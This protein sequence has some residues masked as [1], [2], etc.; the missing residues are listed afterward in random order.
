MPNPI[1]D[2]LVENVIVDDI[3]SVVKLESTPEG[4]ATVTITRPHRR[5]ALDALTI[6]GLTEAF[7]TLHGADHVRLVFLR[8]AGSAFCAGGDFEWTAQAA[9][10]TED[11]NRADAMTLA[12]MVKR[13]A[14]IPAV[15]VALVHGP[16][17]GGGAGLVAAC[18]YAVA[19]KDAPFAFSEVKVGLTPSVVAPYIVDAI[20]PRAARALFVTG[21]AFDADEALRI[22]LVNEVVADADALEAAARR[23]VQDVMAAGPEAVVEARRLVSQVWGRPIDHGLME[24][25]AKSLAHRRVSDEAKEGIAAFKAKRKPSWNG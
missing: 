3:A 24:E 22:G 7:E 6:E 12:H 10:M 16:A 9:E 5:N 23:L 20:G 2:P 18:D 19:V 11:D 8:G 1:S 21:R 25:T 4:V 13:L 15:T 17:Y 14:D